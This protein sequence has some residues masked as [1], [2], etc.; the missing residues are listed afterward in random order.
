MLGKIGVEQMKW[1]P[2]VGAVLQV[3]SVIDIVRDTISVVR[4]NKVQEAF[5]RCIK[6]EDSAKDFVA[7]REYFANEMEKKDIRLLFQESPEWLEQRLDDIDRIAKESL[8]KDDSEQIPKDIRREALQVLQWRLNTMK[9][10]TVSD[11]AL[12]VS[13]LATDI[14][15]FTPA[16]VASPFIYAG[17]SVILLVKIGVEQ[18]INYGFKHELEELASLV[19]HCIKI[20]RFG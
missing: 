12:K 13:Y 14:L 11:I 20:D 19:H 18:Y 5:R 16:A 1:V 6:G 9:W 3:L 17:L 4:A 2:V 7:V 8:L 15:T 10:L